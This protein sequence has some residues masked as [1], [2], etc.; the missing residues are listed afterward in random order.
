MIYGYAEKND[1]N[2]LYLGFGDNANRYYP[3]KVLKTTTD[4]TT[5]GGN[6]PANNWKSIA[7]G[8]SHILAL[9]TEGNIW[10]WGDNTGGKLGLGNIAGSYYPKKITHLTVDGTSSSPIPSTLKWKSIACGSDHSLAIDTGGNMG[11]GIKY[12]WYGW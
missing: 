8:N 2:N 3:Q 5:Q 9:D 10:A 6:I 7:C 1:V 12:V 4:G 11:M